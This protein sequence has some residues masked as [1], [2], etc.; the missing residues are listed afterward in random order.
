MDDLLKT[1]RPA[2]KPGGLAETISD[3]RPPAGANLSAQRG[4]EAAPAWSWI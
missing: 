4:A 3:S 1:R 2:K